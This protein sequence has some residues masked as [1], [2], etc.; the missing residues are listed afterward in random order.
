MYR[1]TGD[2]WDSWDDI[3]P[4]HFDVAA[5]AAT[6]N[7]IGISGLLERSSYPD[8]DMLPLGFIAAA[9]DNHHFPFKNTSLTRSEQRTQMTLWGMARSPL[10]FGGDVK[11]LPNEP[12]TMSLLTNKVRNTITVCLPLNLLPSFLMYA[13]VFVCLPLLSSFRYCCK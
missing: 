5:A 4:S 12:F 13:S 3:D 8:L 7:L 10:F 6:A 2:D 9:G 11:K 1:I